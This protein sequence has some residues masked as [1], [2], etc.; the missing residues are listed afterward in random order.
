[1]STIK[2]TA[3]YGATLIIRLTLNQTTM[4]GDAPYTLKSGERFWAR[5]NTFYEPANVEVYVYRP[6]LARL[7][8]AWAVLWGAPRR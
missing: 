2:P 8:D 7:V 3:P 4:L 5:V 1:M 6:F